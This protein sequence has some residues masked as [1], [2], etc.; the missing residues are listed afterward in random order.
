MVWFVVDPDLR[1]DLYIDR[2]VL[3]VWY[4]RHDPRP[5]FQMEGWLAALDKIAQGGVTHN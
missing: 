4:C 2:D 3:T 1:F 5:L